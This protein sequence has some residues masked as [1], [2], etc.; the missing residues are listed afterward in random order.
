M[1]YGT[2]IPK[3]AGREVA[4]DPSV[5]TIASGETPAGQVQARGGEL[6]AARARRWKSVGLVVVA[7]VA[8]TALYSQT[9]LVSD[10][11]AEMVDLDDDDP[12]LTYTDECQ[13][14]CGGADLTT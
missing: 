13:Y 14:N 10:N 7:T 2:F 3:R 8:A 9:N 6:G 12:Y 5:V 11:V 1:A 4:S